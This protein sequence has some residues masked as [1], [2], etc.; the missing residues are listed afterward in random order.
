MRRRSLVLVVAVLLGG[1]T[2]AAHARVT[3][4][5]PDGGFVVAGDRSITAID[6]DARSRVAV[7][8]NG[9]RDV[10]LYTASGTLERQFATQPGQPD[11][12]LIADAQAAIAGDGRVAVSR[13]SLGQ[14]ELYRPDGALESIDRDPL[15]RG[16][17]AID[18]R[19]DGLLI[20]RAE[21]RIVSITPTMQH[22]ARGLVDPG[23]EL[24]VSEPDAVWLRL[25]GA[26]AR[27]TRQAPTVL[28][29][30]GDRRGKPVVTGDVPEGA[31]LAVQPSEGVWVLGLRLELFAFDGEV[32]LS[33]EIIDANGQ[34]TQIAT[35]SNQLLVVT[36]N[37][38]RR[39]RT[40][41]LR[42]G[43]CSPQRFAI[44]AGRVS[45][46]QS[47]SDVQIRTTAPATVTAEILRRVRQPCQ[48]GSAI[49][50]GTLEFRAQRS[51]RMPRGERRLKLPRVPSGPY[52][53]RVSAVDTSRVKRAD[54]PLRAF[55]VP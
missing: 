14:I 53:L 12:S 48:P 27:L 2:Q 50:C 36:G 20:A 43:T 7:L 46:R 33:C 54:A 44:E 34:P 37:R 10:V 29:G 49:S 30:S 51:V 8:T 52:V 32:R 23:L 28:I 39:L 5:V 40:S 31:V 16:V 1:T 11:P 21:G 25:E 3:G 17:S 41:S 9:A 6:T 22:T 55:R 18:Y 19:P 47:A 26:V 15:L 24:D 42:R 4:L 45:R 35:L 38:I 13:A